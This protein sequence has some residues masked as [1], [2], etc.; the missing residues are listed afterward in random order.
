M[1]AVAIPVLAASTH[2]DVEG[3]YIFKAPTHVYDTNGVTYD[4]DYP[5][6]GLFL[7][8]RDEALVGQLFGFNAS[9]VSGSKVRGGTSTY[10]ATL[11]P[12]NSQSLTP[13]GNSINITGAG[14]LGISL[15]E[16]C[17][18]TI[19]DG[20]CTIEGSPV[21]LG[22]GWNA[23]NV[24]G[25]GNASVYVW[26]DYTLLAEVVGTVGSSRFVI[27]GPDLASDFDAGNST[28]AGVTGIYPDD[29]CRVIAPGAIFSVTGNG[30]ATIVLPTGSLGLAE[31]TSLTINGAANETLTS[32]RTETLTLTEAPGTLTITIETDR[33][34]QMA[35]KAGTSF[36][37]G[38]TKLSGRFEGFLVLS[39]DPWNAKILDY[40]FS[41][42]ALSYDPL[43]D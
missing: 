5:Y 9:S 18:G 23:L 38:A 39:N 25:A 32:G 37:S 2:V 21:S 3:F 26:M 13:G 17:L 29:E 30:T 19:T 11:S 40:S 41:G 14:T 28:V 20:T 12:R 6:F 43:L 33:A 31:G 1:L 27:V 42:T 8:Q 36:W 35:G 22:A 10:N 24:T 34:F 15:K 16:G 7:S 4:F